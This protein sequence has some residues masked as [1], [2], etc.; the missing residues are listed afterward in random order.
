MAQ[1]DQPRAALTT[2]MHSPVRLA[3]LG[4]LRRVQNVSF[5]DLR[6]ALDLNKADLSRQL[7]I[8]E[9]DGLVEL[10]KLRSEGRW[11]TH[12]RL[13]DAGRVRFEAYLKQLRS[14]IGDHG[15]GRQAGH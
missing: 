8:L 1:S 7:N 3:V 11:R 13:S 2:V 10:G 15:D 6:E 12:V 9:S 5:A 4:T 14:V